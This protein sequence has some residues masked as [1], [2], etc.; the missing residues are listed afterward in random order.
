MNI[1]PA[2]GAK[3]DL[4][5]FPANQTAKPVCQR[6]FAFVA[7]MFHDKW[8]LPLCNNLALAFRLNS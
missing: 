6:Y 7:A 8:P 4:D 5:S 3:S 1:H 2:R